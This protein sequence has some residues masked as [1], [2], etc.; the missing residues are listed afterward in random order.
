MYDEARNNA[1]A[2]RAAAF[3]SDVLAG[4]SDAVRVELEHQDGIALVVLVPYTPMGPSR[5]P[6][7]GP[8]T[9][10]PGESRVWG[11]D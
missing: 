5:S 10:S 6:K 8:M 9:M 2:I 4:E 1:T 11:S 7:F 3:V